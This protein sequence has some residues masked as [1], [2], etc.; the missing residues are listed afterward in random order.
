MRLTLQTRMM[1]LK[2]KEPRLR[3][4]NCELHRWWLWSWKL[5]IK[6][7]SIT[8]LKQ[9]AAATEATTESIDLKS[10]EPRLRDWNVMIVALVVCVKFPWN[11]KNLDYEIETAW[12]ATDWGSPIGTWNQKNLDYEIETFHYINLFLRA[13]FSLKSKEPRLRDWNMTTPVIFGR[14]S[15]G[16]QPWNQKNLDYEIET[17]RY[18][19]ADPQ[20]IS[21]LKSKEPRLRDWNFNTRHR[22][23]LQEFT[24]N[25]KNLDYEI[26]TRHRGCCRTCGDCLEIKRTSIT[27]LKL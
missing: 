8:R 9:R 17:K 6:R 22:V 11:Q 16:G 7:T 10:K 5:E 19:T 24:W 27:R 1:H 21:R 3:D 18:P 15:L 13:I 20:P 25:Q 26:E 14:V 12:S 23:L 4:W 2:S